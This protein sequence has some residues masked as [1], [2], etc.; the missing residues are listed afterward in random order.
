MLQQVRSTDAGSAIIFG[1]GARARHLAENLEND[2]DI[3]VV[4]FLDDEPRDEDLRIVGERYLGPIERL[5]D[6]AA[7]EPIGHVFFGLP[8]RFLASESVANASAL[9]EMLG[10]DL[11]IPADLFDTRLA[12]VTDGGLLDTPSFSYSTRHHHAGWKLGVKR[13]IDVLGAGG[14]ILLSLPIWIAIAIAIK[15]GS[16]GPVFFVQERCGRHGRAFPFL[17]FRTMYTDAEERLAE[18][19]EMNEQSGPVFKMKDD[20]R[21]TRVGRFLRKLS[22][23]EVPQLLNV[24]AG[25]MSLVGPRPPLPA[26][27]KSYEIDHRGRL[28]MRPGL[29]CLW[30]VS[31]RNHIPFEDWVKLDLEYVERWSLRLDFEILLATVPAVLSGRGAS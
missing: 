15:L 25:Q 2:A 12:K 31:G 4:G 13:A 17:K 5:A 21:I 19:R 24:L 18:I 16:E 9:C 23:D 10:V 8:R 26:E 20:P 6:L 27:V 30:Q 7:A 29:T 14:A 11:T 3:R 1:T 22:L 28:A